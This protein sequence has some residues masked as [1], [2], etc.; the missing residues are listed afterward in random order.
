[1]SV[2]IYSVEE[3]IKYARKNSKY[4]AELYKDIPED[5]SLTDLP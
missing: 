1:M 2:K 3:I 5:A 4:Y